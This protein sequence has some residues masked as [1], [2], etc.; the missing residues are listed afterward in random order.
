MKDMTF[1]KVWRR[2]EGF[3]AERYMPRMYYQ[4]SVEPPYWEVFILLSSGFPEEGHAARV[5]ATDPDFV[6]AL[7]KAV[8]L[9]DVRSKEWDRGLV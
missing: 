6:T 8:K 1:E 4:P 3:I 5:R 7:E 9:M 2:I